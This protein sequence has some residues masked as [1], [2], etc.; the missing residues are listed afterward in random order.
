MEEGDD[1]TFL[2]RK[3]KEPSKDSTKHVEKHCWIMSYDG[4]VSNYESYDYFHDIMNSVMSPMAEFDRTNIR[5]WHEKLIT[6]HV[7]DWNTMSPSE[8]SLSSVYIVTKKPLVVSTNHFQT[9]TSWFVCRSV[10][11]S[12]SNWQRNVYPKPT[13]SRE[14]SLKVT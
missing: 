9:I 2:R 4:I 3:Q 1:N 8:L 10:R 11:D 12:I 13:Q 14:S 5:T 6:P 7:F